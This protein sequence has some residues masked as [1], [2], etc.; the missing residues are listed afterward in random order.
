MAGNS[1]A[2]GEADPDHFNVCLWVQAHLHMCAHAYDRLRSTSSD[3]QK[4]P[5]PYFLRQGLLLNL[6]LIDSA[7]LDN[8]GVPGMLQSPL[9]QG[10]AYNPD[11]LE[12]QTLL[13]KTSLLAL[14]QPSPSNSA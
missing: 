13:F 2:I 7:W 1:G 11:A 9:P 4:W 10:W 12:D 3:F 8:Q 5:S 6:E 14:H